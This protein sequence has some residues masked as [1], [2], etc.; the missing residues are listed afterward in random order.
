MDVLHL[1]SHPPLYCRAG[2]VN[3]FVTSGVPVAMAPAAAGA[4]SVVGARDGGGAP[5]FSKRYSAAPLLFFRLFLFGS[6][7]E[8]HR[9]ASDPRHV[10]LLIKAS[11]KKICF[12]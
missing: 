8:V 3:A 5:V 11:T 4:G 6:E 10:T 2:I 7:E 1:G 12:D 9:S